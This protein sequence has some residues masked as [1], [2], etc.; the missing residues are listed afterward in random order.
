MAL[1]LPQNAAGGSP[2]PL[3]LTVQLNVAEPD[4]P[5]VSF[6]VTVALPVPVA[7][8]VPEIRPEELMDSPAGSPVALNVSVCPDAESVAW[9]CRLTAIP[10]VQDWAP[11]LV[12]VTVLAPAAFTVQLNVAEPDAPVVSLAVTVTVEVPAVVGVPEISPDEELT[13]SPAGSPVA[14]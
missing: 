9:I 2:D 13:D 5:V 7:V 8:A 14:L 6:A 3:A 4:A 12:T 11:G 1:V 10:T